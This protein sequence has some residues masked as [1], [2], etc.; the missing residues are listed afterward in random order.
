MLNRIQGAYREFPHKFWVVVLVSFIDR[1][2]GTMLFPFFS[3]YITQKFH[4]GMTQS[5]R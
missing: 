1:V 5:G 3:L 2:G 4:V